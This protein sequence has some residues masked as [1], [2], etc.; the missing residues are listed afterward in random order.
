MSSRT[1][2]TEPFVFKYK[3]QAYSANYY[4]KQ[5]QRIKEQVR[6][7]YTPRTWKEAECVCLLS[8]EYSIQEIADRLQCSRSTIEKMLH[9]LRKRWKVKTNIGLVRL[10]IQN[11]MIQHYRIEATLR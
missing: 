11:D 6:D 9:T 10:F 7:N 1:Q 2:Q 5:L 4:M 8:S 3:A